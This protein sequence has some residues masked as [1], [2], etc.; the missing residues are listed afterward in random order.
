MKEVAARG[1]RSFPE[2]NV[3]EYNLRSEKANVWIVRGG[4]GGNAVQEFLDGGYTGV[5]YDFNNFDLSRINTE[6]ALRN[7]TA[8]N[9]LSDDGIDGVARFLIKINIGDYVLMP[10]RGSKRNYFGRVTSDP[11]HELTGTHNNRRDVEWDQRTISQAELN[12]ESYQPAVTSPNPD[13]QKRYLQIIADLP[14]PPDGD[15]DP[16]DPETYTIKDMLEDG[17]FFDPHELQRIYDRFADKQNLIL[18]GP[19]G[20]GKTFISEGL[21]YS[22]IGE[23]ARKRVRHVQ[24]HQSY[25][26]EDFVQGF[27][28][29]TNESDDLVFRLK[30][31]SFKTL[32]NEAREAPDKRFVMIIDEINR[33]NLSRVFG[34]LLSLIEK[35]KRGDDFKIRLAS[36]NDFSVPENVYI[37]GMMNL[38]DRSLAGMDYAMRRRFAFVTLKPQFGES[39]FKDWLT[40]KGVP[41]WMV[42]QI[43]D[44]MSALNDAIR[45][46]ESLGRNF[47]VGHSYFCDVPSE[48]SDW[49]R[50]DWDRWYENII[51]TEI[52][53]LLEEYWFDNLEK[54]DTQISALLNG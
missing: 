25:S 29:A 51:E 12:L 1:N 47:A 23:E 34:E 6:D 43:N 22:L 5:G 26:Y 27:R 48:T 42:S 21:A 41:E 28:P 54:A 36:G 39:V 11:Y 45:N 31:G 7:F 8:E 52:R 24:F 9:D 30:D 17:V 19:P 50:S 10:N 32:C 3:A 53:P 20:V 46:D 2:I 14:L 16:T 38:A 4:R 40:N 33:G 37:L 49:N 13:R 44:R 35:D 15:D 18:Q